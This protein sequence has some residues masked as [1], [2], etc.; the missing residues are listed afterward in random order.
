LEQKN[1]IVGNTLV[2]IELDN[3]NGVQI[4][5]NFIGTDPSQTLNSGNLLGVRYHN[6]ASNSYLALNTIKNNA[7][8]FELNGTT[9]DSILFLE[10]SI[11]KNT[12]FANF[13]PNSQQGI[14]PPQ[15][16]AIFPDSII[17]GTSAPNALINLYADTTDQAQIW[18][19]SV[20][21]DAAGD[22]S[23]KIDLTQAPN[24][25]AT[26]D[27]AYN[28]SFFTLPYP[29]VV[30]DPLFVNSNLDDGTIGTF[31]FAIAYANS[32]PNKDTITFGISG[33]TILLDTTVVV[34]SKIH[35]D[36]SGFEFIIRSKFRLS[37]W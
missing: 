12:V 32:L 36:A 7:T 31:R 28:S 20:R 22:W 30:Q 27:S 10:N 3:A 1:I 18:L 14:T 15:I 5:G 4:V 6:G 26:Q 9:T 11:Y 23:R 35:I 19:D 24:V 2:G 21:A 13:D 25:T 29:A 34:D 16:L 17:F 8:G 37:N 33:Q